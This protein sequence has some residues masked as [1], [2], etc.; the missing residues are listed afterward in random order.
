MP[1]LNW[2]RP[3]D[4]IRYYNQEIG[5]GRITQAV[6]AEEF[7]AFLSEQIKVVMFDGMKETPVVYTQIVRMETSTKAWEKIG[8]A[9]EPTG[10]DQVEPGQE[11]PE[12]DFEAD[13]TTIINHEFAGKMTV[14]RSMLEDDQTGVIM[15]RARGIGVAV[16]KF[17]DKKVATEIFN[18]GTSLLGYDGSNIFDDAHPNITGGAANSLNDNDLAV[19]SVSEAN[20][21]TAIETIDGWQGTN[22]DEI[23]VDVRLIV[24]ARDE[25]IDL[26]RLVESSGRVLADFNE[27]VKN[28]FQN[29]GTPVKWKRLTL[30]DWYI[31]TDVMGLVFQ[32]R[33]QLELTQENITSGSSFLHRAYIWQIFKRFGLKTVNWRF[34]A[35]CQ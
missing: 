8:G 4:A 22:G 10:F 27:G 7:G 18:N 3:T 9:T 34:A 21:Q 2:E 28:M 12:M 31:L 14:P 11:A 35:K 17:E 1:A 20:M 25:F 23:D 13:T 16:P 30:G 26:A 33:R 24:A 6:A 29:I 15:A 5:E 19:G 32:L